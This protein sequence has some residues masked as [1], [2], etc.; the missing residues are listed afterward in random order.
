MSFGISLAPKVFQRWMHQFAEGF[1]RRVQQKGSAEGFSRRVQ[2]KGSAEGFSGV[3]VIHDNF[4]V[5]GCSKTYEEGLKKHEKTLRSV[6]EM[7]G[8]T[9]DP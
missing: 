5:V 1:S 8:S 2:Q 6:I 4:I 3:E 7:S 9:C